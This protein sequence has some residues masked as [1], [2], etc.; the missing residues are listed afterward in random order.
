MSFF[1]S[2]LLGFTTPVFPGESIQIAMDT[3]IPGDTVLVMPGLHHGDGENLLSLNETHNGI[4]LLGNNLDPGSVVLSGDSI[5]DS[6]IDF[7]CTT[8]GQIDSTLVVSGFT[9]SDGSATIDAFGG[10]IH[11]KH[12]SPLVEFS[13]FNNCSSDNGGAIYVWKGAPLIRNCAF[14]ENECV[15][16]G[17]AIYLY[18]SDAEIS[19]SSFQDNTS[20][21]DGGAVFCYHS[22]PVLFNNIFTGGYAHDDGGAVYCYAL[23][24][25]VISF[26]T[27]YDNFALY[28]GSAVY[29]RVNSSPVLHH[30]IV[31]GNSGPAFYIQDGGEP[32]FSYNC[33]WGNP[34]GNYGNLPDPTG[35]EGN[36][37]SDPLFVDDFFLSQIAAGQAEESP[38]VDSG[39]GLPGEYGLSLTWTRTDSVPDSSL[40][41]MGYHHSQDIEWQSSHPSPE[42]GSL[43]VYPNPA[44]GMTT[45]SVNIAMNYSH[46]SIFDL[47]GHK[48]YSGILTNN[49]ATFDLTESQH[50]G[51]YL[52]RV[53]G[54][55]GCLTGKLTIIN[56]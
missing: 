14:I 36:I 10:A 17:A 56:P 19:H 45:L 6:I 30:N 28:T 51:V 46:M 52:I 40:V 27:F 53:S 39:D 54:E 33:V 25:P 43:Q 23:S 32:I 7:D 21:D 22:S 35:T 8:G 15:S 44:S 31:T 16:A 12:S 13:I 11:T 1:L 38:C 47:G 26:C 29:F 41:D 34:D 18:T 3:S 42:N 5:S 4:I 20:W 9:F 37:S 2:I 49:K 24:S 48:V 50:S 55:G